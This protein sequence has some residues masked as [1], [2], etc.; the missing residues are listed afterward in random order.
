MDIPREHLEDPKHGY[1][2]GNVFLL[3]KWRRENEP[4]TPKYKIGDVVE[5]RIEVEVTGIY[6]DCDGTPLYEFDNGIRGYSGHSIYPID[7]GGEQ[8]GA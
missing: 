4:Q 6:S 8:D 3:S 2:I 7:N 5:L 1:L